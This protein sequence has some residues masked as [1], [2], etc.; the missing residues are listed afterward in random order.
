MCCLLSALALIGSRGLVFLI[1]LIDPVRFAVFD[2]F[3]VPLA[4]FIF[5]PWTTL[6]F[7]AVAPFGHVSGW[8]WFWLALGLLADFSSYSSSGYSNRN[9]IPGYASGPYP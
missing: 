5:L 4:G 1:W 7:V 3:L 8:D 6:M 2:G 9:R